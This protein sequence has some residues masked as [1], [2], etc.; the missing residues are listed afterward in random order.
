MTCDENNAQHTKEYAKF[1]IVG[2]YYPFIVEVKFE[3]HFGIFLT[4]L[5]LILK[6]EI[7]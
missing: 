3:L 1:S 2:I 6:G 7:Y 5:R 4:I